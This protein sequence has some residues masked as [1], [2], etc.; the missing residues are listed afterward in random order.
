VHLYLIS[1]SGPIKIKLTV[2]AKHSACHLYSKSQF[3]LW[4]QYRKFWSVLQASMLLMS[5]S[6]NVLAC[7][8]LHK[9][10]DTG[11][12]DETEIYCTAIYDNTHSVAVIM[13]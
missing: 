4:H 9:T 7:N 1:L 8:T 3:H 2:S 6:Y 12:A 11:A 5:Q 10:F 13:F